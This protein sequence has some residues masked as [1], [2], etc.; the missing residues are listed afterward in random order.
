M[1]DRKINSEQYRARLRVRYRR[2]LVKRGVSASTV[3]AIKTLPELRAL[4]V[5]L[6]KPKGLT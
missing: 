3:C 4:A 2:H 6:A 1:I 5:L